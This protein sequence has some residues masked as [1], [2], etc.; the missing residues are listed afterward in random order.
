MYMYVYDKE[1][2]MNFRIPKNIQIVTREKN[3]RKQM[4]SM[5][6]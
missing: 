1:S 5:A 4:F 3:E 6:R 2:K